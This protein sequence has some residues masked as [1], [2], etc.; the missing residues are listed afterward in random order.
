MLVKNLNSAIELS[1][2]SLVLPTMKTRVL[3]LLLLPLVCTA[4]EPLLPTAE[5]TTWNYE[6]VQERPSDSLDL[7]EP[8]KKERLAVTYRM[9]GTQKVDNK[10]LLKLE[11]YRGDVLETVD[12]IAVDER[13]IIS[14]A[15]MDAKGALTKFNPPQTMI[16][17]PLKAGAKWNFDGTIGETK[18]NQRY[19]VA[20]E[21]NVDVPAGKFH[22][23]RIHCEQTAPAPAT[24]ERWFVQG[25]G[26]VKVVTTAKAPSGGVLQQT[27]LVL[28]EAPK[29]VAQPE[30]GATT[31]WGKL[32]VTLSNERAGRA[33]TTF[34]ARTPAIYAR[35]QG[36]GLRPSA[37]VRAMWVVEDIAIAPTDYKIDEASA[38]VT[39]PD[40]SGT[41]TLTRPKAGWSIG[42]Y[43]VDFYIDNAPAA[44]LKLK[45]VK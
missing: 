35:W 25:T 8:N 17:A 30:P 33:K 43:R 32:S 10:D 4:A 2:Q 26:F 41:F 31:E 22:A 24:I 40:S 15:R 29:V 20:G 39:S 19:E 13:G 3:G 44:T 12:L 18:V 38:I 6:L 11:I 5:G 7:T 21:E 27:S 34:R 23:W 42:E 37:S 16:T 36:Q 14:P 9:A 45:I 1:H 28:K